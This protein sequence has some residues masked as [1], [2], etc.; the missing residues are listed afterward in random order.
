MGQMEAS[1]RLLKIA[2]VSELTSLSVSEIYV[3]VARQEFPGPLKIGVRRVAWL[4]PEVR[5]SIADQPRV[6]IGAGRHPAGLR[7]R[8]FH[9]AAGRPGQASGLRRHLQEPGLLHL[10]GTG[11]SG[12]ELPGPT[13]GRRPLSLRV[14]GLPEVAARPGA[15]ALSTR[16]G[17]PKGP[18]RTV[19]TIYRQLS[20]L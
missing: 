13:L 10:P 15:Q 2:E 16:R 18:V 14:A 12:G 17:H 1:G 9:P 4:E 5:A 19:R 6:E 20:P 8:C 3:R 11:R 7:G